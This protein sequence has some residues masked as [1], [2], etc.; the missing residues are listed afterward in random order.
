HDI[1]VA[2]AVNVRKLARVE[3][4]AAPAA[5]AGTPK[6]SP[7]CAENRGLRLSP[8]HE[9]T[10]RAEAPDFA[11]RNLSRVGVLAAPA[12]LDIISNLVLRAPIPY[13]QRGGRE[14]ER[15]EYPPLYSSAL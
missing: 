1:G 10:V 11:A 13:E 12:R 4:L 7:A 8:F 9:D 14:L 3:V 2:V 6:R 5:R 15:H